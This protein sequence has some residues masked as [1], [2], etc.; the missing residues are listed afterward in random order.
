MKCPVRVGRRDQLLVHP[1]EQADERIRKP[2]VNRLWFRRLLG[3]V[4]HAGLKETFQGR[5]CL[6]LAGFERGEEAFEEV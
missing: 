1:C 4:T 6:N 2:V 5:E 3:K